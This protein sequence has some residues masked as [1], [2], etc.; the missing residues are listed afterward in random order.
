MAIHTVKCCEAAKKQ[1][2]TKNNE[3]AFYVMIANSFQNVL[4]NEKMRL[5][6]TV[7]MMHIMLLL[8]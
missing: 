3:E 6:T 8:L 2:K 5:H 7:Y 1:N 4:L